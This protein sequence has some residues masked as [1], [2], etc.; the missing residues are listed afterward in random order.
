MGRPGQG[1]EP[2][3]SATEKRQEHAGCNQDIQAPCLQVTAWSEQINVAYG[4]KN[5]KV[6][7]EQTQ[8]QRNLAGAR[9]GGGPGETDWRR[10]KTE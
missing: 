3:G 1:R 9:A 7:R 2:W 10:Q 5:L 4:K 8:R 6:R